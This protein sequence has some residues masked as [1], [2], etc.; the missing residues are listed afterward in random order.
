MLDLCAELALKENK[1]SGK[2]LQHQRFKLADN[3]EKVLLFPN[4]KTKKLK[5]LHNMKGEQQ[6]TYKSR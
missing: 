2:D 5:I 4:E 1:S 6:C 3:V